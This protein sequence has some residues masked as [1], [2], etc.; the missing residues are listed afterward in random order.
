MKT[1]PLQRRTLALI[2]VLLPMLALTRALAPEDRLR[3]RRAVPA[4]DFRAK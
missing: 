2:A 1:P 3:L 4:L